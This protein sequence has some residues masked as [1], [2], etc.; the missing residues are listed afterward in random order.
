MQKKLALVGGSSAGIGRAV[1]EGLLGRGFDVVLT[2]RNARRL[3]SN[4]KEL[5]ERYGHSRV[6]AWSSDYSSEK[7]VKNLIATVRKKA[8]YPDIIVLNSGGP[9]YGNFD[10]IELRQWDDSYH[11]Q[12]RASLLLLKAF[13]PAMR[14]KKWGRIIN[15]SSTIAIEPSAS[16]ILSSSYRAAL[17]NALKAIS[18]LVAKEGVT[19][20]TVCPGAVLTER[21]I[22]LYKKQARSLGASW[23]SLIKESSERIPIGHIASAEEFAELALFLVDEKAS[24]I[25]GTVIPVDGGL[26]KKGL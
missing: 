20:N 13:L 24:Y 6:L 18:I 21:L 19:V 10:E 1:A 11:Q 4:R 14:Q 15:I 16:M 17:I 22:S 3:L 25:T 26:V 23:R 5:Q 9:D 7:S 2:A 12:L 8:G